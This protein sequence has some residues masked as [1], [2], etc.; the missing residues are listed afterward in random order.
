MLLKTVKLT[1]SLILPILTLSNSWTCNVRMTQ[2]RSLSYSTFCN[3]S[4]SRQLLRSK[5]TH[6]SKASSIWLPAWSKLVAHLLTIKG[7]CPQLRWFSR[8]SQSRCKISHIRRTSSPPRD[9]KLPFLHTTNNLNIQWKPKH[10]LSP[11]PPASTTWLTSKLWTL[12]P[13]DCVCTRH[14]KT[15]SIKKST[16]NQWTLT[17]KP[18]PQPKADNQET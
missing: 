8:T 14:S 11:S 9:L 18:V 1:R 2:P 4:L 7:K 17:A 12:S 6:S 5:L 15:N 10:S 13:Q 3:M 16:N